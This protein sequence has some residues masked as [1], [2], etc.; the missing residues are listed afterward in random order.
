MLAA[1]LTELDSPLRLLDVEPQSLQLG[2]VKV[3]VL[4]SGIC[5]AQLQELRGHK[6]NAKF[7]P[8]LLG[9]EGCGIVLEVG[10]GVTSCNVG[11]KV[12]M[13]WRQSAGIESAF[14]Q[15]RLKDG[16]TISGG[17]VTTL[18]EVS[19]CS[20]NRLTPV[21]SDTPT[22]FAALLGCAISTAYG[23]VDNEMQIKFGQTV[24]ILGMG[25]LGLAVAQAA[26]MKGPS[27]VTGVDRHAKKAPTALKLG[28]TDFGDKLLSEYDWIVDTTG[29]E[30]LISGSISHLAPGGSLILVAQPPPYASVK[31]PGGGELFRGNGIKVI[32]TQG[33]QTNP[34]LDIP[35]YLQL[36][37][38]GR[39][40]Y[41]QLISERYP[42]LQV[43]E[44]MEKLRR[45]TLGRILISM[46]EKVA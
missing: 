12:V 9:H 30:S 19:I 34:F 26:A 31:L 2:Q 33:G 22:D 37:L 28:A 3:K 8:H 25:G 38:A 5:G 17:K 40:H 7:L 21:P 4:T 45:G 46:E 14:P 13:H 39:L 24:A 43:N 11:D 10:P 36:M 18:S 15:Y 42:L 35:R 1:V 20:E 23:I 27:R 29:D 41:S 16:Q 6:G 44:A 32:A